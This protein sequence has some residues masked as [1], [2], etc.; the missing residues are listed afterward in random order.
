MSALLFRSF[1]TCFYDNLLFS[2]H[3]ARDNRHA[4]DGGRS[5]EQGLARGSWSGAEHHPCLHR[6]SQG[7]RQGHSCSEWVGSIPSGHEWGGDSSTGGRDVE[8]GRTSSPPPPVVR[9]LKDMDH[10]GESTPPPPAALLR[11]MRRR[12]NGYLN[13]GLLYE[14]ASNRFVKFAIILCPLH[15]LLALSGSLR[16]WRSVCR[17]P[18]C[19][20]LI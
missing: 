20:W 6:G 11:P 7:G 18:T 16:V 15:C 1:G 12:S 14:Q 10:R 19:L 2:D 17:P 5:V 3:R 4:E 13:S 9:I 8:R